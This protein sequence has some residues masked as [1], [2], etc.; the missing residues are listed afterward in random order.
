MNF[1]RLSQL[2]AIIDIN[3]P[4]IDTQYYSLSLYEV[5][6]KANA[7][8]C[9]YP[10]LLTGGKSSKLLLGQVCA[11]FDFEKK[12]KITLPRIVFP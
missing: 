1:A 5:G 4:E 10:S 7:L 8:S 6:F 9:F 12:H 3:N 11:C 2:Y